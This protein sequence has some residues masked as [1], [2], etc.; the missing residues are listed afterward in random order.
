MCRKAKRAERLAILRRIDELNKQLCGN[1]GRRYKCSCA[2][3]VEIRKLGALLITDESPKL[4][5]E[6]YLARKQEG[7]LDK[8]IAKELGLHKGTVTKFKQKHGLI[9]RAKA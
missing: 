4:T 1:C 8:E 3:A 5:V 6:Y 2:A 7:L 9:R